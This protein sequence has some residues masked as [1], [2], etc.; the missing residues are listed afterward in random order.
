MLGDRLEA[1][2]GEDAVAIQAVAAASD[3]LGFDE[4]RNLALGELIAHADLIAEGGVVLLLVQR[5]Q[6]SS[7]ADA[8][9]SG[10]EDALIRATDVIQQ[11]RDVSKVL[12]LVEI[13]GDAVA[14]AVAIALI[15]KLEI[16]ELVLSATADP[17]LAT[18]L[19]GRI[20]IREEDPCSKR[21][22]QRARL[23]SISDSCTKDADER[24]DHD[25]LV[26]PC[27]VSSVGSREIYPALIIARGVFLEPLLG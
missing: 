13:H 27:V 14:S 19:L 10:V 9:T 2:S 17:L 15:G 8:D 22:A 5:V 23:L 16:S 20:R 18:V 4:D 24:G 6:F 3:V 25:N 26:H 1:D 21:K 7:K 11:N 12:L